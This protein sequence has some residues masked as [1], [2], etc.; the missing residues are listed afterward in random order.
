[1]RGIARPFPL[2][3]ARFLLIHQRLRVQK[4][5]GRL[6]FRQQGGWYVMLERYARG[7]LCSWHRSA[8]SPEC[9]PFFIDPPTPTSAE[10]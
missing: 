2:N 3:V 8:L 10:V 7:T 6:H 4:S 5:N 1:T 9:C